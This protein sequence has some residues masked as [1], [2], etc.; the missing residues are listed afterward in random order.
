MEIKTPHKME[1]TFSP[2]LVK[3]LV[4]EQRFEK[5]IKPTGV[6][7]HFLNR[8][9]EAIDKGYKSITLNYKGD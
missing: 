9:L 8:L 1:I 3:K 7:Y 2:Q 4:E 5:V 6:R